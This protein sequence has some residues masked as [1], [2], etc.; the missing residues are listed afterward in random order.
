M[1]CTYSWLAASSRSIEKHVFKFLLIFFL[2]L[3]IS[4]SFL[5]NPLA[6]RFALILLYWVNFRIAQI[7]SEVRMCS[8]VKKRILLVLFWPFS[9]LTYMHLFQTSI[10]VPFNCIHHLANIWSLGFFP[11]NF[12]VFMWLSFGEENILLSLFWE[13]VAPTMKLNLR[14]FWLLQHCTFSIQHC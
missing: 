4:L 6:I 12:N 10:T 3:E 5:F 14:I 2:F 11:A 13:V 8:Y 9:S 1:L 7:I